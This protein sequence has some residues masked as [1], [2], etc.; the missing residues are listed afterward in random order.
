[1]FGAL[2]WEVYTDGADLYSDIPE[3]VVSVQAL[4]KFINE[5]GHPS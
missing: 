4:T 3:A 5:G 1:M 2:V